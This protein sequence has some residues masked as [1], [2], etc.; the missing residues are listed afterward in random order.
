MC[1]AGAGLNDSQ[2]IL[3][4]TGVELLSAVVHRIADHC[5]VPH[6]YASRPAER[7]QRGCLH[8][9]SENPLICPLIELRF[10]FAVRCVGRPDLARANRPARCPQFALQKWYDTWRGAIDMLTG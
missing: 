5:D 10:C 7:E 2:A 1:R 3:L 4:G 6:C 8:L 9:D